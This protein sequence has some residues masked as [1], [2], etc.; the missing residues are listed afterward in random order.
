MTA[1]AVVIT[2][3]GMA[4]LFYPSIFAGVLAAGPLMNYRDTRR[5]LAPMHAIADAVGSLR[6][7]GWAIITLAI[8]AMIALVSTAMPEIFYDALYYH[9][10]LPQ[11]YL[12]RGKIAWDP[13]V[14]HSAFP[15]YLDVLFG[16]CLGIAGPGAAKFFNLLLFLLAWAAT[17]AFVSQVLGDRRAA[18]MGTM[19]IATVPG[20]LVMSTMCAIDAALIGF[21]AMSAL[22]VARAR[23]AVTVAAGGL[24]GIISLGA[25]TAGFIAGSK[26]T[27]L[28]LIAALAPALVTS[29][30]RS[31][32][33]RMVLIFSATALTIAA[34]W[35]VRNA[36]LT[37]DPLYP[38]IKS[39]SGDAD[40]VWAVERLQR[41]VQTIGITWTA[42]V[43]LVTALIHTPE[44]LGAGAETGILLPFGAVALLVGAL[45]QQKLRPWTLAFA[46]Y[47]PIW[48]S[49]TGVMRYLYPIFPLCALGIAQA[50]NLFVAR[51]SRTRLALSVVT[52]LAIAPLWQSVAV[53]N[54]VYVGTDMAALFSGS[55]S[56]HD[57]LSRRLAYYQAAQ[58]VN[59]H[60]ASDAHVLYLG[61][62]RLLYVDRLVTFTSAYDA[63]HFDRLLAP[64]APP[65]WTT[66]KDLRVTHILINGREIDRLRGSYEYLALSSDA[67]RQLKHALQEC[68][69]LFRQSGV[70][71]CELPRREVS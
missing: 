28:W 65:L 53:L 71:L 51:W 41:D 1:A 64:K 61:E 21:S 17:A 24:T 43:D 19:T 59:A 29:R 30:H 14:V 46:L 62:T 36:L 31:V 2:L 68:R 45:W 66:L 63:G 12:L 58:W 44:R 26:Y 4:G 38:A 6:G 39:W 37:G 10:G 33:L 15:A 57:Y 11:Q 22:A 23:H 13:A 16:V 5:L 42:P 9:L 54:E 20:V 27:G 69:L 48:M 56:R 35:Y 40:A 60:T 47:L 8:P 50:A 18:L 25:V 32:T 49:F 52:L 70:Q 7:E 3:F 34:P 67:E 55:L